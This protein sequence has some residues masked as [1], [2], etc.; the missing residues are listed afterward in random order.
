[1]QFS[2]LS[3]IKGLNHNLIAISQLYDVDYKVYFNKN[4][5][6]VI[7]SNNDV[8]LIVNHHNDIYILDMFSTN[9]SLRRCFFS[10]SQSYFNWLWHKRL[11]HLNFK[12]I[13]KISNDPLV[14]GFSK[15]GFVKDKLCPVC[16]NGK[17]TKSSFKPK[18]F[19]SVIV[20]FQVWKHTS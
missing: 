14:R 1:M 16:E 19:S 8:V 7:D 2:N 6:R 5:G 3:Y 11:S 15:M 20:M 12:N 13:S 17:Q 10:C 9:K 4:E 18:Q